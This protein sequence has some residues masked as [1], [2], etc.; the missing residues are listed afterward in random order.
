[1]SSEL[2]DL[3]SLI[4][5]Q[6]FQNTLGI[7]KARSSGLQAAYFGAYPLA[8][9]GHANWLLRH[10]SF[11]A[12]F[13]WGLFLYGVGALI[14][15]PCIL[16]RSFGGFC[17]ATFIIGNGLGA[18]ETAA[19]PYITICGPPR[20]SELRINFSQAFNGIGTV[21]APVLGS[22]VFFR[23]TGDSTDSLRSTQWVYLA[24]AC[25]VFLLAVVFYFS[26]L[27]EIT[28]ADMAYQAEEIHASSADRPFWKQYR[29]FHAAFAQFCYTGAQVAIAS[30]FINYVVETTDHSDSAAAQLLAGAQGAFTAG[31][32]AGVFIMRYTKPRWVFLVYLSLCIVFISPAIGV[33]GNKGIAM[34]YLTL[35]FESICFPTIVALGMRGLGKYSKR[36]SGWIVAGVSGGAVVPPAL[37]GAADSSSTAHAMA[38]PLSFF[39]LAWSYS[40][41]VN[42]VPAYRDPIDMLGDAD[43]GLRDS[44]VKDEEQIHVG[45]AGE[46]MKND[47]K[48]PEVKEVR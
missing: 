26:P 15:W 14:A 43:I 18:L 44:A 5:E 2:A 20:Y 39:V 35:F 6:H 8:S 11:K 37:G 41:A 40:F 21:V 45:D 7:T 27:P 13:I 4:V 23:D 32:F 34:L 28:D 48:S 19:N 30:Y 12:T 10:Y 25:F 24:I 17:A 33:H 9:L 22:Y 36:G 29:L 1:M 3:V 42:F 47:T 16:Y 46:M 31:R 38:V